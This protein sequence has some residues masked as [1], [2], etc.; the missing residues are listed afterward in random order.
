LTEQFRVG[1][2]RV[3]VVVNKALDLLQDGTGHSRWH[4]TMA[5]ERIGSPSHSTLSPERSLTFFAKAREKEPAYPLVL[6]AQGPARAPLCNPEGRN[7]VKPALTL[8][9][10]STIWVPLFRAINRRLC[11]HRTSG[12]NP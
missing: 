8:A 5:P 2:P 10:P 6:A 1:E 11:R 7:A 12:T 4:S 3:T 9:P